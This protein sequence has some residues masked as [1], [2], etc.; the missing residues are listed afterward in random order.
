M[1][2]WTEW[3]PLEEVVVGDCHSKSLDIWNLPSNCREL[4]DKI[5]S[6]TKEDLDN[7]SS[8]LEKL[9]VKVYRPTVLSIPLNIDQGPFHVTNAISPI[10]PR[11]QYLVYDKTIIQTYTSMPSRYLDSLGYYDIFLKK[12]LKGYNW[13]SQPPPVLKGLDQH[14]QYDGKQIYGKNYKY[15]LLWHTATMFKCGDSIIVNNK[16]PGSQLGLKWVEKNL[17]TKYIYNADTSDGNWGHIDQGFFM[18]DDDTVCCAKVEWVPTALRNKKIIE[19]KDC[20]TPFDFTNMVNQRQSTCAWPY[21]ISHEWLDNWLSEWKGFAQDVAAE[22]NVLVVDPKNVIF[23][24]NLPKIF[25]ELAK[26]GINCH[27]CRFRHAAFWEAGV[28]CLT[29]DIKR[30]GEKRNILKID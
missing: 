19:L 17:P 12:F 21:S 10:V 11:D 8:Y 22:F 9:G 4:L 18:V 14:W 28:H 24:A 30:R 13:I 25:E 15:K 6:E 2:I 1:S 7:I 26:H 27:F 3:D 20:Y 23:S 29:L 5:L 16:G